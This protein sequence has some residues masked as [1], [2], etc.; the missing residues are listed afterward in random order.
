MSTPL[1]LELPA[2]VGVAVGAV[3][4]YV[5]TSLGDRARWRRTRDERWDVARME[6]YAEFGNAVKHV[7]NLANTYSRR[8]RHSL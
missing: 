1:V 5:T 8:A 2:L 4:T 7:F 3:A 6:A